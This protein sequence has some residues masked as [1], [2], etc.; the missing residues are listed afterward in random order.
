V[1]VSSLLARQ[2]NYIIY[3]SGHIVILVTTIIEIMM[4]VISSTP[5]IHGKN[6]IRGPLELVSCPGSPLNLLK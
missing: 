1:C 2:G 3:I 5:Y 6:G 4:G